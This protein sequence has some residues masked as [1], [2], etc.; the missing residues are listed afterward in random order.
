MTNL[1]VLMIKVVVKY[2]CFENLFRNKLKITIKPQTTNSQLFLMAK[3]FNMMEKDEFM[4]LFSNVVEHTPKVAEELFKRRPFRSN[5]EVLEHLDS[6]I[7]N[8]SQEEK[9]KE[10]EIYTYLK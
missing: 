7:D 4:N 6:V 2:S 10:Q 3:Q 8:L 1:Y 9:V 5:E